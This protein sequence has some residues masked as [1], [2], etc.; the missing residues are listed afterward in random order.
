MYSSEFLNIYHTNLR[1]ILLCMVISF[2]LLMNINNH[3]DNNNHFSAMILLLIIISFLS[4]A[5]LLILELEEF[6]KNKGKKIG[7]KYK[8][9]INLLKYVTGFFAFLVLIMIA[10]LYK[11]V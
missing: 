10:F 6:I 7:K 4:I 5:I 9:I 2:S 11:T 1:N 3:L 8:Y